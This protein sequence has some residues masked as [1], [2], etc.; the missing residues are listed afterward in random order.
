M[1]A[2]ER[3]TIWK[4]KK[5]DSA[6]NTLVVTR[7]VFQD[8]AP[9]GSSELRVGI[10]IE[11]AATDE[12]GRPLRRSLGFPVDD[13][14]IAELTNAVRA[15]RDAN[16]APQNKSEALVQIRYGGRSGGTSALVVMIEIPPYDAPE[17]RNPRFVIGNGST[18]GFVIPSH[19]ELAE[20]LHE[21]Q[22][23]V[24]S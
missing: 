22:T 18:I 8:L 20:L 4:N 15:L 24:T 7:R 9:G 3:R 10:E 17:K 13:G 14:F 21:L 19:P 5:T 11:S 6:G 1:N 23:A 2:L 12:Y 16:E